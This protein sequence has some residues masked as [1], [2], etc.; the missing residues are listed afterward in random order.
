[1]FKELNRFHIFG[2][3]IALVMIWLLL[4]GHY[5]F[6]LLGLGIA[7]VLLVIVI[8]IRMDVIDRK[9][10]VFYLNFIAMAK[11][12]VWLLIEVVKANIDV[13]LRIIKPSMPITPTVTTIKSGQK[14]ELGRVVYAN[15][16]TM[17]PSTITINVSEGEIE[18]HA[19]TVEAADQLQQGE[20]NRRVSAMESIG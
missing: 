8:S 7:S 11:Y 19:L 14:T 17:T 10:Y 4:S 2:L 18:V 13:C 3:T 16:I 6:M 5:T 9:R 15:S 20:M 1:V 12:L